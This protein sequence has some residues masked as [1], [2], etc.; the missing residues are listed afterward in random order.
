MKVGVRSGL[1]ALLIKD[2]CATGIVPACVHARG[3][4]CETLY[5]ILRALP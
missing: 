5:L 1:A 4:A 3:S 2:G